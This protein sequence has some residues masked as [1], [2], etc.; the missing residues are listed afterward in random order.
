MNGLHLR[1]TSKWSIPHKAA[2]ISRR[3]GGIISFILLQLA[4]CIS[5]DAMFAFLIN[6]HQ[7]GPQPPWLLVNSKAGISDDCIRLVLSWVSHHWHGAKVGL[8][9]FKGH[10]GQWRQS[11]SLSFAVFSCQHCER[12]GEL[13]K[14]PHMCAEE[15]AKPEKLANF[16]LGS[17]QSGFGNGFQLVSPRLDSF[18]S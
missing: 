15:V 14:I 7:D 1:Y 18:L 10:Q 9:L 11:P 8:E 13:C 4:A 6:L 2:C 12:C 3:N 16:M 5:N 17:G